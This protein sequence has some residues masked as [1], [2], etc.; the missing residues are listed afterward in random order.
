MGLTPVFP[1]TPVFLQERA[2][3]MVDRLFEVL[4]ARGDPTP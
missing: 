4:K 3:L 2:R 1:L